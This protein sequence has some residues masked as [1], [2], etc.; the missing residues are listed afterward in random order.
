MQ[1]DRAG[2]L[3]TPRLRAHLGRWRVQRLVLP[4]PR[5]PLRRQRPHP[6]G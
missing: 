5:L 1:A 2:H 3:N 6:Q 4:L